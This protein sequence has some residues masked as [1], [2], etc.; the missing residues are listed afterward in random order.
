MKPQITAEVRA[1][2]VTISWQPAYDGYG[3]I[4]NYTIEYKSE[5]QN[6]VEFPKTIPPSSSNYTVTG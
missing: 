5:G 6:W 3:P 1:R 2:N 4:R